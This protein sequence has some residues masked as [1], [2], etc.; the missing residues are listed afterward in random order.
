MRAITRAYEAFCRFE[1]WLVSLFIVAVTVLVFAGGVART[2]GHPLNWA[3]DLS[4]LLMAWIVFLGGDLALRTVG[5][6]SVTL[7][8]TRLPAILQRILYYLFNAIAIVFLAIVGVFGMVLATENTDRLYQTLGISYS[9]AALSAP[10]GC[11]LLMIT[12]IRKMW[13]HRHG[14]VPLDEGKEAI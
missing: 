4:L 6:I 11:L 1:E 8:A 13:L 5:F 7:L 3:T 14:D 9:W 10:V 2:I 12:V